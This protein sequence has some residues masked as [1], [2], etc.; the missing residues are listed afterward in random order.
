MASSPEIQEIKDRLDIAEFVGEYL[1][2]VPAGTGVYKA[3]CPFHNEKTPSFIVSPSRGSFHCFG[4]GAGG[5][6]FEFLMKIENISFGEALKILAQKAGVTLSRQNPEAYDKKNRLYDICELTAK[7]WHRVLLESSRAQVARDYLA[8]RGVSSDIIETFRIGYAVDDWGNLFDFLRKR[9]YSDAEIFAAGFCI[10]KE[11]GSGYYDRF[12]NRVM[13]PILDHNGRTCGFTGR[14]LSPD[15]PAKYVNTPQTDIYNKSAIVFAL[16][17]AKNEIRK[18]D[19][20]VVVEGQM[21]AVSCHQYGFK[22][23][24]ASSGTALTKEQLQLLKRFTNNIYFALDADAAGQKATDRGNDLLHELDQ[25]VVEGRDSNGRV[26]RFIDPA[27]SYNLNLKIVT[28]PSGKDP[29]ECLKNNPADWAEA[30]KQAQPAL[31]YFWQTLSAGRDLND[32]QI[33]KTLGKILGEK[34]A[35]MDDPIERDYWTHEIANRLGVR[36]E[37]LRELVDKL[38][39]ALKKPAVAVASQPTTKPTEQAPAASDLR[40]EFLSPDLKIFRQILAAV[41]AFPQFL[42]KLAETL[43]PE[44]LAGQLQPALY[45][46]LILFYTKNN[47]LFS[48]S[49]SEREEQTIFDRFYNEVKNQAATVEA[50]S[51]LEQ[52]YLLAQRDFFSLEPREAKIELD[53]LL[54]LLKSGYFNREITRLKTDLERAE[55]SGDKASGE[56]IIIKLSELIKQ[57][58]AI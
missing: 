57:K 51:I 1:K 37:A 53:N 36:D 13:F 40:G 7:Y 12:R 22:N 5:D 55:R 41:W 48:L 28:I 50:L 10:K 58:S 26:S 29:D 17:Q 20:V 24:V 43:A 16:H 42:P 27:L 38:D 23:T 6:I 8:K 25:V 19:F 11:R 2:L 21:D 54:R 32:P 52:S 35:R 30:L 56:A 49:A 3:P 34:I 46:D 44:I 14:T 47:E 31:E 9:N 4:C 45:K 15:E 18:N 39:K 33:K